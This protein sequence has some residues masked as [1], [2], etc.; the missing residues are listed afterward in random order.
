[1]KERPM[2]ATRPLS[3][4]LLAGSAALSLIVATPLLAQDFNATPPNAPG[5][6]PAFE[7]QTRAPVIAEELALK[8]EVLLEGLDRAWGM[9][10]LPDGTWLITERPGK[11]R[12]FNPADGSLSDPV[13]GL[14]EVSF[15]QQGGLLDVAVRDDFAETRRVWLSFAEPRGEGKDSTSV[16]TGRLSDDGT[17]LEDMRVIFQQ[18]PAWE[19]EL[20]YGSRLVFDTDGMLFV[21]T[22]E[23]SNPEPR[24]LAQDVTTHLGKVLRIDPDG[25]PAAG[26][27]AIEG[28]QPE[29]WSYGHR[30]MQGA[31]LGPDGALWTV[32]HG[33]RGGDEINRPDPGVNY[34]WPLATYGIEYN[35]EPIGEG[36]TVQ[37]G[38]QQPLYYW[39][40]VIAPS[41]LTFYE[42][43]MFPD[44]N[45][46]LLIGGLAGQA[47]VRVTLD[48]T[49][50]TG[51]QRY[52]QGE[53]RIRD[54]DV[55]PDGA[56]LVLTDGEDGKLIRLTPEE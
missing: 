49:S 1:M 30:N 37:D 10:P 13:A 53:Y 41:G 8:Q 21:T 2:T 42:G 35:G 26:N 12:I 23:R 16:A 7:G 50:V 36:D 15:T 40:P 46:S 54:V 24:Q 29:I 32:E 52:L 6:Q 25:G 4:S 22:G 14:P 11:L 20:H 55:A 39:D 47:L 3:R 33:A 56:V 38:M 44:W 48:G 45:G 18:N 27:P 19:S 31:T 5:Q 9:A 34:G 17:T 28:G 43:D 51:E